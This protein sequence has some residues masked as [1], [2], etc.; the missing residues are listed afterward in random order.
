[1]PL[2]YGTNN[3]M[4]TKEIKQL[5]ID[6][7]CSSGEVNL[8]ALFLVVKEKVKDWLV[9]SPLSIE[10]NSDT[11]GDSEYN[12]KNTLKSDN[13]FE[14]GINYLI[15]EEESKRLL[16]KFSQEE[17]YFLKLKFIENKTFEEISSLIGKSTSTVGEKSKKLI[18]KLEKEIK[19][20]IQQNENDFDK[21]ELASTFM[22]EIKYMRLVPEKM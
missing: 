17:I 10:H 21:E 1:M 16:N 15:I 8:N 13:F 9:N 12:L 18:A 2:W 6:A 19:K 4:E 5:L 14:N 3:V 22:N 7:V 11:S 20:I